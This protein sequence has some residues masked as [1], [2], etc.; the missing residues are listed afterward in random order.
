MKLIVGKTAT[1]YKGKVYKGSLPFEIDD[2][3][4]KKYVAI[5]FTEVKE[6]KKPETK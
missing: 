6:E 1:I 4:L 3:E 5:G 2:S